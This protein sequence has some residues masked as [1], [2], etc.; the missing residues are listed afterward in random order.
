[1]TSMPFYT[2]FLFSKNLLLVKKH[3][4]SKN[5]LASYYI[6]FFSF[7]QYVSSFFLRV[8]KLFTFSIIPIIEK[9]K[10]KCILNIG[11]L[12][13]NKKIQKEMRR[14]DS[15]GNGTNSVGRSLYQMKNK[16]FPSVKCYFHSVGNMRLYRRVRSV[17]FRTL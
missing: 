17:S 16:T 3:R 13:N 9:I 10:K 14:M 7:L 8:N 6:T 5:A 4:Q 12:L 11:C 1:M 15:G 2:F